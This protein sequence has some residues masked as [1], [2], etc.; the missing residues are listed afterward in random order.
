MSA[1]QWLEC[2][3]LISISFDVCIL[4]NLLLVGNKED[5]TFL[6]DNR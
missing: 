2:N 6:G 1:Y 4:M 5:L 3:L